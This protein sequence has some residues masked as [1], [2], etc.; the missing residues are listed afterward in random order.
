MAVPSRDPDHICIQRFC[1][2]CAVREGRDV[3]PE[4]F[5][6]YR[7]SQRR[8]LPF[9][10]REGWPADLDRIAQKMLRMSPEDLALVET[11]VDALR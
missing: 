6:E 9:S 2:Y 1:V 5:V 3:P 8:V 7:R 10:P 4:H 11:V